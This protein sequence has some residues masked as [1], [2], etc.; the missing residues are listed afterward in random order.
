MR[1]N[2][3]QSFNDGVV[4]L[5]EVG[6]IGPRGGMRVEG[7]KIKATLRYKERT[8]GLNRFLANKQNNVNIQYLLRCPRLRNI[9]T[10]DIA[11]P[12]DGKQFRITQIQYPE[13]TNPPVMDITL[14]EVVSVYAI[15]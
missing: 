12:N 14:E 13:E 4:R 2:K 3:M 9:S 7:L 15:G 10:Q 1:Q 8:V 6:N 5:Y 11:I